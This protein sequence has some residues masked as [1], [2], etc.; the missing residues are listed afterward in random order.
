[1]SSEV[2][3]KAME[4]RWSG[5]SAM[6]RSA[7]TTNAAIEDFMSAAPRPKSLPSRIVGTKGSECHSES[8]P[9][10]TT[11]V[12]PA[13]HTNGRSLPRRAQRFVTSP[14]GIDS[15]RN[16]ARSRRRATSAWQPP[17]CGVTERR[18]ISS[19]ANARALSPSGIHVDLEIVERSGRPLLADRSFRGGSVR[20]LWHWLT[21]DLAG[22]RLVDEPQH[23]GR[24][25]GVRHGLVLRDLAFHEELEERL[26]E[27]LRARRHALLERVLDLA[28]LAFL[29]QLRDVARVEQHLHRGDPHPGLGSY[30][31]LRDDGL[32]RRRQVE[33][34]RCAVLQRIEVDDA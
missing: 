9:V 30:Q 18:S 34:Q 7:A 14:K 11:S 1:S 17:S 10:G 6:K 32:Q 2:S 16:P 31:P 25:V 5:R 15:Q 8:G 3:R 22:R 20:L 28:E 19:W 13:K 24:R 29:D 33:E 23:I 12:W 21:A 26:L 4:P 27:G